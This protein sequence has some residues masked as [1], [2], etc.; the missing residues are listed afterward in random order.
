MAAL[1]RR[2]RLGCPVTGMICCHPAVRANMAA[3]VD[4]IS[5]GRLELGLGTGWNQQECDAYGIELPPLSERFDRFDEGVEVVVRLLSD[6]LASFS[7]AHFTLCEARCEPKP[8]QRPHPPIVIGGRGP[9]RRLR[10]A[11]RFADQWNAIVDDPS[12]WQELREIL[13]SHCESIGRDPTEISSSVIVRG[14]KG[15]DPGEVAGRAAAFGRVG[16]DL[17][18]VSLPHHAEPRLVE[19]LEEAL[20]P[21][22]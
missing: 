13:V 12:E 3:N 2:I 17:V 10:T 22:A 21:P 11:A 18:F 5:R 19:T 9:K 1:T 15:S 7:G 6:E 4:A 14:E 8:V 16:V 20:A